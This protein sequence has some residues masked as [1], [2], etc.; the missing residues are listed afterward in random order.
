M[1]E[2]V[3]ARA[4]PSMHGR[5][6]IELVPKQSKVADE[7]AAR[8][9]VDVALPTRVRGPREQ[10]TVSIRAVEE[11]DVIG[12]TRVGKVLTDFK[13]HSPVVHAEVQRRIAYV[14]ISD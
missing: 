2:P 12:E 8:P 14:R 5:V 11:P 13:G 4:M 10:H 1:L 6:A 9:R 3:Q 7:C